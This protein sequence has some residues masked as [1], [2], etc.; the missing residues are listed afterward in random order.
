MNDFC[1]CSSAQFC[2][3]AQANKKK[4]KHVEGEEEQDEEPK[5]DSPPPR[6]PGLLAFFCFTL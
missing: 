1:Y 2:P 3:L 6:L 5:Q 4:K